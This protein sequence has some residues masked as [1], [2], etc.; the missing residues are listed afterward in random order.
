MKGILLSL[1]ISLA[2]TLVVELSFALILK[3]RNK[4]DL[5]VI[6]LANILTNP[7]VNYC[8]YWAIFLFGEHS[9]YTIL[10]ITALEIAAVFAE[11][12]LYRR[13]LTEQRIG[14]LKLSLLLNAASFAAGWVVTGMLRLFAAS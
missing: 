4:K 5:F 11:F 13:L 14:K 9:V 3:V 8:Y 7:V 2:L 6:G 10:I 12:F 1:L